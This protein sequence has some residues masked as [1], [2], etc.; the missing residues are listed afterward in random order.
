MLFR[1]LN[2]HL[3]SSHSTQLAVPPNWGLFPFC[4]LHDVNLFWDQTWACLNIDSGREMKQAV[5]SMW[6]TTLLCGWLV[7]VC[8]SERCG[9]GCLARPSDRWVRS[10]ISSGQTFAS[11]IGFE[12]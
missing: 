9:K 6:V 1:S 5:V 2:L 3:L 7:F 8:R 4:L 12:G 10:I 11:D